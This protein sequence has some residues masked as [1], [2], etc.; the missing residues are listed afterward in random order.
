MMDEFYCDVYTTIFERWILCQHYDNITITLHEASCEDE[1]DTIEIIAP[2]GKGLVTFY[3]KNIIA[4]SARSN[5]KKNDDFFL[6]FQMTNLKHAVGLFQEMLEVIKHFIERPKT[7]ILLVCTGGMTTGYFAEEI[8]KA[9][10]VLNLNFEFDALAIAKLYN[11]GEKYDMILLAPQI[12]YM[13]AK[14]KAIFKNQ[15][16]MKIPAAVFAKY[17]VSGI[18]K[19]IIDKLNEP[20]PITQVLEPLTLNNIHNDHPILTVSLFRN[21]AQVHISYRIYGQNGE[22]LLMNET[23]KKVITMTDLYDMLNTVLARFPDIQVIGFSAP[24]IINDGEA[25]TANIEGFY[26]MNYRSLFTRYHPRKFLILN[27]V[28]VAAIGYHYLH[29]E[30]KSLSFLFQPIS[31]YAGVGTVINGK[32]IKGKRSIAGEV[33]FYPFHRIYNLE[34]QPTPESMMEIV[35]NTVMS[36]ITTIGPERMCIYCTLLTSMDELYHEVARYIPEEYIPSLEK[37][38]DIQEY[39]FIGLL[40]CC[41]SR[42]S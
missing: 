35:R 20:S 25:S 28:N 33:Q 41:I 23:I 1:E 18:F 34:P 38:D 5:D 10:D 19:L 8:Q 27:D 16:I 15:I 22:I 37:I 2:Y 40:A 32:L 6:H 21:S 31:T 36:F 24:G 42:M 13:Y 12:A 11:Q 39:I 17:D 7:R 26:Q 3:D 4:M 29:P 14:I 9:N 30:V